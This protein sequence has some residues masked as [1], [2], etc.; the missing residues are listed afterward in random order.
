MFK[1]IKLHK[2]YLLLLSGILI[3][4][5][6]ISGCQSQPEETTLLLPVEFS[7][8]PTDLILTSPS[9]D[10]LEVRVS[11]V[12]EQIELIKTMNLKYS[13]DLYTDLASDPAGEKVFIDP[14]KYYILVFKKRIYA[15]SGVEILSIHPSYIIVNLERKIAKNFVVSVPYAGKP[16]PGYIALSAIIEPSSVTLTGPEA[17][18]KSIDSLKTKPIDL[19]KAK[20]SFKRKMPFDLKDKNTISDPP[21]VTVFVPVEKKQVVK[22]FKGLP[23]ELRNA[24]KEDTIN[25]PKITLTIKGGQDIVNRKDLIE[26]VKV[27]I[28]VKDLKPGVYVRR[29]IIDLPLELI[30]TDAEPDIFTIKIE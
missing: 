23:V 20:E 10:K 13:V 15:G 28:D 6:F 8:T 25:P 22:T 4:T 5:F 17:F 18:I 7:S 29:A 16:V 19:S 12:R 9:A 1:A 27:S 3:F 14:R 26:K 11:G 21:I 2:S 24:K 30:M